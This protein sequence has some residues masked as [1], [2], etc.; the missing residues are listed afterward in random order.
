MHYARYSC[1]I[2]C[3]FVHVSKYMK[4]MPIEY[5]QI[6]LYSEMAHDLNF[7]ASMYRNISII[8]VLVFDSIVILI[9]NLNASKPDAFQYSQKLFLILITAARNYRLIASLPPK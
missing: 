7:C 1:N 6:L 3:I 5:Y 4:E 9:Y 8:Y 2:N